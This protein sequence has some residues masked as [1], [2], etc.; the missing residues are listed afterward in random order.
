MWHLGQEATLV[1][2]PGT[3]QTDGDPHCSVVVYGGG[4][5]GLPGLPPLLLPAPSTQVNLNFQWQ[6][7]PHPLSAWSCRSA[8]LSSPD[9]VDPDVAPRDTDLLP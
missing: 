1:A 5:E 4:M 7:G 6:V 2:S 9:P 3:W 8:P